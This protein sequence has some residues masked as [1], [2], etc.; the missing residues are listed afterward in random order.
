[1]ARVA[2]GTVTALSSLRQQINA[3]I[4]A[5]VN[6]IA[7][8]LDWVPRDEF[9][10]VEV[11]LKEARIKQENMEKRISALEKQQKSELR[12]TKIKKAKSTKKTP[13]NNKGKKAAS[14][15]K[16]PKKTAA[17]KKGQA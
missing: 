9:E 3:E 16:A 2:G 8:R 12:P 11:M 13:V 6:E 15:G 5:R 10:R 7:T 1:M 17:K 4:R 14:Q